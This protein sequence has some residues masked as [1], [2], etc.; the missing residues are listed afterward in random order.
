MYFLLTNPVGGT[1]LCGAITYV[2]TSL[3]SGG[4]MY[5]QVGCVWRVWWIYLVSWADQ[6][7]VTVLQNLV[8]LTLCQWD[9]EQT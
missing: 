7:I 6:M 1:S 3:A 4:V 2:M 9:R 8:I 5:A